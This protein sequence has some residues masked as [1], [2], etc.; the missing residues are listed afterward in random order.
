MSGAGRFDCSSIGSPSGNDHNP[1]SKAASS[2]KRIERRC[3]FLPMKLRIHAAAWSCFSF[4]HRCRV[5][6]DDTTNL[7]VT[8]GHPTDRLISQ[9]VPVAGRDQ[10]NWLLWQ[11]DA[12]AIPRHF[13]KTPEYCGLLCRTPRTAGMTAGFACRRTHF[14]G[15]FPAESSG[16]ESLQRVC[17]QEPHSLSRRA[18][19]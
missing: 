3:C 1:S 14:R 19:D 8:A 2:G 12:G 18:S 6:E 17:R 4:R 10:D 7:I 13:W 11:S 9:A 15:S 16:S 5:K